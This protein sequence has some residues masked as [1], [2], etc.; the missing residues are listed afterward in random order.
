MMMRWAPRNL[1]SGT[2]RGEGLGPDG[3][4]DLVYTSP[5]TKRRR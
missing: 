4:D 5:G 2:A 1:P 3:V